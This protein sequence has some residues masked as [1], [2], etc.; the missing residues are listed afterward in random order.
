MMDAVTTLEEVTCEIR[1][2][3][4]TEVEFKI[5][6]LRMGFA[7]CKRREVALR[8]IST[9]LLLQEGLLNI[10]YSECQIHK[11]L[12]I[13]KCTQCLLFGHEA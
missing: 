6:S 8:A 9:E 11:R 3:L 4:G 5:Q 2:R 1:K 10:G 7:D 12:K 13:V